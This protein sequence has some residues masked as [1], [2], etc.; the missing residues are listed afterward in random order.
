MCGRMQTIPYCRVSLVSPQILVK[1]VLSQ[2]WWARFPS[3]P[4][5]VF[6]L[7]RLP[8]LSPSQKFAYSPDSSYK[9]FF[10]RTKAATF[11]FK[12]Q[13]KARERKKLYQ[14]YQRDGR[15][16]KGSGGEGTGR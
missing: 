11:N 6:D 3:F 9:T 1:R 7:R 14:D 2:H 5:A 15:R 10:M 8:Y 4:S 16:S 13:R 12:Q